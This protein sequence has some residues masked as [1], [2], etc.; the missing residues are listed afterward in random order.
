MCLNKDLLSLCDVAGNVKIYD[1]RSNK[2][3]ISH[4]FDIPVTKV[5]VESSSVINCFL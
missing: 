5:F 2:E 3:I 1:L 4:K